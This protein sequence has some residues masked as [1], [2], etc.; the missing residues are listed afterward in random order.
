MLVRKVHEL[1][2]SQSSPLRAG[3]VLFVT[4]SER[5][6]S[7]SLRRAQELADRSH[8]ELQV[9]RVMSERQLT[10]PQGGRAGADTVLARFVEAARATSRR[11]REILASRYAEERLVLAVGSLRDSAV[12]RASEVAAALLVIPAG[13]LRGRDVTAL[14]RTTARPVLVLRPKLRDA[15]SIVAATDLKEPNFPVLRTARYLAAVR[16]SSVVA[17]HAL[18]SRRFAAA[19]SEKLKS[20][21][22]ALGLDGSAL[23]P[24]QD[25]VSAIL[26]EAGKREADV[27]VVGTHERTPWARVVRSS[28][29]AQL[30]DRAQ[31]SV[32]VEPMVG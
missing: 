9:L 5:P 29:A 13:E 23:L 11:C 7:A 6:P 10:Q 1:L 31:Q 17:L 15:H 26:D 18:R 27:I 24:A 4:S 21:S 32:W 30:I 28:I 19:V 12:V 20:A 2:S 22:A 16:R 25:T 8:A 3:C 14:A